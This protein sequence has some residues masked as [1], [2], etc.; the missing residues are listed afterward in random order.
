M[1]PLAIKVERSKYRILKLQQKNNSQGGG[2][3]FI[4]FLAPFFG[5]IPVPGIRSRLVLT[6]VPVGVSPGIGAPCSMACIQVMWKTKERKKKL[7]SKSEKPPVSTRYTWTYMDRPFLIIIHFPLLTWLN[8]YNLPKSNPDH[9]PILNL[10]NFLG[11]MRFSSMQH[12]AK[13]FFM[14]T[15]LPRKFIFLEQLLC[16]D[17]RVEHRFKGLLTLD[18]LYANFRNDSSYIK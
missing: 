14:R 10:M 1:L 15:C 4:S 11:F 5:S 12:K 9:F 16:H 18:N 17:T 3:A 7:M 2:F 8:R 6:Q 13:S